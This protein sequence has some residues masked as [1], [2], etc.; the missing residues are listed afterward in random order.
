VDFNDVPRDELWQRVRILVEFGFAT[1]EMLTEETLMP[2]D[3]IFRQ[4]ARVLRAALF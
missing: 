3:A 4:A 1:D 2:R